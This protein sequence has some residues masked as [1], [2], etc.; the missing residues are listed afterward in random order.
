[1]INL[2][3]TKC[4][5]CSGEVVYTSNADIYGRA[6]GSGK[7]YRCLNCGAYVGTHKPRPR[8]ALGILANEHMRKE[9]IRC[10]ELFDSMWKDKQNASKLR[11]ELYWLLSRK[12]NITY[13]DCHFGYFGLDMLQKAYGIL[14]EMKEESK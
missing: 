14:L 11:K 3:P 6:F 5:L 9:K 10:H 1:M 12:L 8:E 13:E 2:Y 4:N 7:C